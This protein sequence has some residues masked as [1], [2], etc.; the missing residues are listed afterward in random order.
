MS[1]GHFFDQLSLSFDAL[2][3]ALA[4]LV[5]R[6]VAALAV[7]LLTLA[8]AWVARVVLRRILAGL[9]QQLSSWPAGSA[10]AG[11]A[12]ELGAAAH[13]V[14][15]ALFWLIVVLGVLLASEA[16]GLPVLHTWIGALASYVPKVLLALAVGFAG[17][18]GG[19]VARSAIE[20][21]SER[22]A[23]QQARQLGRMT[24]LAFGLLGV[25][26]AAAQLGLD[27][28]LLTAVFLIGLACTLAGA[29]LAFGLGAQSVMS[30]ILA[31]H[32]INKAYGIGQRVR[33]EQYEGRIVR[34]SATAIYLE[35]ADGELAIPGR[36]FAAHVC[37][38]LRASHG[39]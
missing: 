16:L 31:M 15:S 39:A 6:A 13:G 5:P 2:A 19:R 33:F 10:L 23:P 35:F 18:L 36:Q 9:G 7:L 20:R 11:G 1:P 26:V 21:A 25:L 24:Q 38:R 22:I 34:T 4:A 30:D 27:V 14:S 17:V 29:A 28:S 37:V 12:R 32:Y 3:G 8:V